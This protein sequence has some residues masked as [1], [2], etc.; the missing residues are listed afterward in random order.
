MG[1]GTGYLAL[2][3]KRAGV[4]EVWAS[5]IHGPAVECARSNV[6]QNESVG[7]IQV[8]QSDL[9][10]EIPP[11][12]KFDLVVLNQPFGPGQGDPVCGCGTDGGYQITQRFLLQAEDRLKTGG[13]AIMA[14][15]DREPK[16]NSPQ[17][18]AEELGFPVRTL[19][20]AFYGGANNYIFEIRP[21][22]S[23]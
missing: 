22:R 4:P 12:V 1:C 2:S 16:E 18:V 15:S 6:R 10:N 11:D 7:P 9:F 20:H 3:L 21:R 8:V 5:D 19:L 17:V 14:F 23:S 13:A